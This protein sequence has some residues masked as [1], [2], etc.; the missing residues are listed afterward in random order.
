MKRKNGR[1][2]EKT[3]KFKLYDLVK[4]VKVLIQ[5]TEETQHKV[6]R[7][8]KIIIISTLLSNLGFELRTLEMF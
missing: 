4:Q 7:L 6:K 2:C 8:F 5:V 1:I 3:S